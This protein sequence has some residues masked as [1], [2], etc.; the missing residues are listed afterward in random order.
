MQVREGYIW[1]PRED[2]P[3]RRSY[4][5]PPRVVILKK[6]ETRVKQLVRDNELAEDKVKPICRLLTS[7]R[8]RSADTTWL[9]SILGVFSPDDEIFAK[10]YKYQRPRAEQ[11]TIMV[12]NADGLING[13]P[14]LEEKELRSCNRL[15]MPK[16][17]ALN[18][19]IKRMEKSI[20]AAQ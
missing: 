13:L 1:C 8:K 9:V 5:P 15:R 4:A 10:N 16:T 19:K 6:L 11:A 3:R 12:D 14:M 17:S 18:L 7:L 20:V 2:I